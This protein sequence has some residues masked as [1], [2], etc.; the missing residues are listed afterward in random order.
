[1]KSNET[2]IASARRRPMGRSWVLASALLAGFAASTAA[3]TFELEEA[4]TLAASDAAPSDLFGV[5][6]SLSGDTVVVGAFVDDD[7]GAA[8]TGSAYVFVREGTAW[9]E[10]A[11]LAASDAAAGDEFGTSVSLSGET[12]LVGAFV[13]DHAGGA[14]AGSAYVFVRTGTTWTEQ[15]KLVAPDAASED[16]FGYAVSLSGET[17]IV[18][19]R[20]DGAGSAYVFVRNGTA[21][22]AQAKLVASDAAASDEF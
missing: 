8:D 5:S 16:H 12:A 9:T 11:K 7:A 15:A 14:D 13:D 17:A 6:V 4:A 20:F 2:K 1:M 21:W 10:Q 3:Q 18:G 22:T 19:A